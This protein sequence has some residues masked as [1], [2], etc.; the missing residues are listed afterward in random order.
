MFWNWF[1]YSLK[2]C[3]LAVG[4][5]TLSPFNVD[6][7]FEA[8]KLNDWIIEAGTGSPSQQRDYFHNVLSAALKSYYEATP[9]TEH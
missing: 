7:S 5:G 9:T 6:K 3:S 4:K 2:D 8:R 1:D